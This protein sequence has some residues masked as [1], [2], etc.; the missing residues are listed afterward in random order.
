MSR[1]GGS[2]II[3]VL[4][5]IA[6]S[7][8]SVGS[9][10]N[11]AALVWLGYAISAGSVLRVDEERS[12]F[13]AL[14]YSVPAAAVLLLVW[15]HRMLFHGQAPISGIIISFDKPITI[16]LLLSIGVASVIGIWLFGYARLSVAA[17]I[18]AVFTLNARQRKNITA[19][20]RWLIVFTALLF[21]FIKSFAGTS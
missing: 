21:V 16:L 3:S 15:M 20:L 12:E 19:T 5:A 7:R 11:Q 13:R 18:E 9:G 2:C 4:G 1:I 17:A 14:L 10:Y 8:V 6:I